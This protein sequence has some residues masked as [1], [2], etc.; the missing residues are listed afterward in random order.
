MYVWFNVWLLFGT[1]TTYDVIGV[2]MCYHDYIHEDMSDYAIKAL[3]KNTTKQFSTMM[4]TEIELA[5]ILKG[6]KKLGWV[7]NRWCRCM[8]IWYRIRMWHIHVNEHTMEI[9]WKFPWKFHGNYICGYGIP[10]EF[11]LYVHGCIWNFHGNSISTQECITFGFAKQ[12][13]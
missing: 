13:L 12:A 10:M 3:L 6:L 11:P 9:T 7:S 5:S 4:S 1:N 2:T 8:W